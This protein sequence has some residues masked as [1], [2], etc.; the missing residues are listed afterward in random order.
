MNPERPEKRSKRGLATRV[1]I[2]L[3]LGVL[4]GV[5]FGEEVAFLKIAGD[6]FIALL[7]ITVIPYVMIALTTSLGKLTLADAKALGIKAGSVLLVLWAVGLAVVFLGPLAFPDWPS[8]TFFSSSLI[9]ESKHVD[10]LKLYIP[11]NVFNALSNNTVPAVVVFS[12]LFGLALINVETK[13]TV[14]DFLSSVGD[15]LM[16]ITAFVGN[17]A[18]YGVFAITAS[19]TGT[20]DIADFGRLQVYIVVYVAMVAVLSLW[21]IPGL[22]AT[23]TPLKY[24]DIFR[25]FQA[26]LITAFATG[27]VLIVLPLLAAESKGLLANAHKGSDQPDEM[28]GSSVDILIPASFPFPNL[29]VILALLFVPFG[30]WY[31]GSSISVGDYPFLAVAGVASLFGGTVLALPFLF[32]LLRLPA[33]L[34]QVFVTVDVVGSRFGTLLAA[35][36][37]IAIALIGT[38]ALQGKIRLRLR[39]LLRFAVIS[40]AMM[41]TALIGIRAF[42]TYVYVAPYT[43]ARLLTSLHLI[44]TPQPHKMYREP[45]EDILKE[46]GGPLGLKR[47]KKRGFLRACYSPDDYPSAFFNNAGALVGFDVEMAHRFARYI[48]LDIEFLPIRSQPEAAKRINSRYCDVIMSLLPIQPALTEQFAFT[49]PVLDLPVGMIVKDHR[50]DEFR[51]WAR[52]REMKNLRVAMADTPQARANLKRVLPNATPVVYKGAKELDSILATGAKDVDAVAA[53]A[54][55][56]SAWTIRYPNFTLVTPEPTLFLPTG[57]AVARGNPNLLLYLDTWLLNAKADGTID[58]LYRYWMLGQV[59][60][61]QPP[62]WSVIRNVLGWIK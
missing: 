27:N 17:L 18:P 59:K 52:I 4:A 3:G 12:I 6:A 39:P 51:E 45:P 50:R 24:G 26:P 53:F 57:Y 16:A 46:T 44:G 54:Q 28:E 56:G 49:S 58:E 37:I 19:A 32:D 29:G 30:G 43:K 11:A 31:V 48:G 35:L 38:Y 61:T 8:A 34:F 1:F 13:K 21:L 20:I 23:L 7:Q 10:F 36:H 41:A 55:E 62:R 15:A 14:L 5:F 22:I 40:V 47:F 42:Y 9:E 60:E 33:D 25:A 2:G